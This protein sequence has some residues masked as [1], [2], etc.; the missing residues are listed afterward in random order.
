MFKLKLKRRKDAIAASEISQ[1][2]YCPVSWHL[3]RSGFIPNSPA[4]KRGREEH[5]KAGGRL[6]LLERLER[7][8]GIF[9]ILW[10]ISLGSAILVLG[11][12]LSSYF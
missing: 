5:E 7:R 9:R 8:A 2:A 3:R 4:L 12:S 1:F 6:T 10:W 11:W